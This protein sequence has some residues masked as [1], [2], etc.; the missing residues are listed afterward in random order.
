[1]NT[2]YKVDMFAACQ[3]KTSKKTKISPTGVKKKLPKPVRV[4]NVEVKENP[5]TDRSDKKECFC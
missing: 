2:V 1:M 5:S 3:T 4:D